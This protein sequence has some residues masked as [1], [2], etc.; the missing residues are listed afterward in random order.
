[1]T[2]P[3]IIQLSK[4]THVAGAGGAPWMTNLASFWGLKPTCLS[5][6][7]AASSRLMLSIPLTIGT[8]LGSLP[9]AAIQ[10]P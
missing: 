4:V 5:F 2:A 6:P 1:M 8:T 10:S 7:L 3:L 9:T